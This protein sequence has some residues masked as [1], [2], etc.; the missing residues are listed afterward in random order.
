MSI[1]ARPWYRSNTFNHTA[2]PAARL[3]AARH[4]TVSVCLPARDEARTIGPII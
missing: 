4:T 2:F 1:G 3:A